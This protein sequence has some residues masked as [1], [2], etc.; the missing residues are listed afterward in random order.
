M[1]DLLRVGG[2][3]LTTVA[4]G[5]ARGP[6]GATHLSLEVF[7]RLMPASTACL[8]ILA[9]S[10]ALKVRFLTA[11]RLLSSCSTDDAPMS[12]EV[13]RGSRSAHARAICARDWPRAFAILSR[14]RMCFSDVSVSSDGSRD[15]PCAARDPAGMPLRYLLVSMPCASG[16]KA[17]RPRPVSPTA[18]SRSSSIQRLSIEYE[19]WWMTTG[20]PIA[21]RISTASRVREPEYDEMPT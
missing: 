20:V 3:T 6:S 16:E 12:T 5:D 18:S 4:A 19:G 1:G 2:L 13:T 8:S 15:F 9:S 14:A 17:M 10:S 21:R 11:S 7:H